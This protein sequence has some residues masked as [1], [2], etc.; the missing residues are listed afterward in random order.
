EAGNET[1]TDE[2]WG[3]V[4]LHTYISLRRTGWDKG[5]ASYLLR[6]YSDSY[7]GLN[8][9]RLIYNN[10]VFR[11]IRPWRS[12]LVTLGDVGVQAP[13]SHVVAQY[14]LREGGKREQTSLVAFGRNAE[15]YD[16]RDPDSFQCLLHFYRGMAS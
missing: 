11:T 10:P 12:R 15:P 14:L 4:V 1:F 3:Q 2:E 16:P 9:L 7:A 8:K 6:S 13:W 5:L